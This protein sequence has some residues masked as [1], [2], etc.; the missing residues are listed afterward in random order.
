MKEHYYG[1]VL[2][3]SSERAKELRQI[4]H[5]TNEEKRQLRN[6]NLYRTHFAGKGLCTEQ[7]LHMNFLQTKDEEFLA[8]LRH[9]VN[10]CL[11]PYKLKPYLYGEVK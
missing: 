3:V 5:K 9:F 10:N 4:V 7:F 8:M 11:S 1:G 6:W 2:I